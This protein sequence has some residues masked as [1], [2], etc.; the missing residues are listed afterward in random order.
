MSVPAAFRAFVLEVIDGPSAPHHNQVGAKVVAT[1]GLFVITVATIYAMSPRNRAKPYGVA[2]RGLRT[3]TLVAMVLS[4]LLLVG[5]GVE[6]L[7]L[8]IE[9][10]STHTANLILSLAM[11][12][13]GCS[14]V[15]AVSVR[16]LRIL[17]RTRSHRLP[18]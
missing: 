18:D 7:V 6:V 10:W 1:V 11:I 2:D 14:F 17:R 5:F 3:V 4:G 8:T 16:E 15:V 9:R 12:S 13:C